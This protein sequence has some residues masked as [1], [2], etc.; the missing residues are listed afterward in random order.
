M[1]HMGTR[2]PVEARS[3][4]RGGK[5]DGVAP[6]ANSRGKFDAL[7]NL[8][9]RLAWVVT[10]GP[11]LGFALALALHFADWYDIGAVE[12]GIMLGMH[13]S[14]LVGVELGFHRLFAHRSYRTHKSVEIVF[15]ALG[16]M[17]FQGPAIWWAATH[18]NHHGHSDQLGDPHSPNLHGGGAWGAIG[19]FFHAHLGW[20]FV[21][22]STRPPGWSRLGHDL[23]RQPHIFKIHMAYVYWL[24][25][26]FAIPAVV[27]GFITWSWQGGFLGFL[28]GG[29]VR[30]FVMNHLTYWCVNSVAH[31]IGARPFVTGDLSTNN[32]LFAI[33]TLGQTWHNNHH[34]FPNS[35]V[36]GVE[37]WQVDLGACILRVLEK[38]GLV[39]DLKV[40]SERM[41]ASKRRA[42][43]PSG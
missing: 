10:L 18:R 6:P 23:Y 14:C 35:A 12:V 5:S 20:L 37:W 13:I 41:I 8:D 4:M 28:W 38:T 17:A 3:D 25:A 7:A 40:P 11:P 42:K 43:Q 29:P 27:G 21:A 32:A 15:G 24:F 36:M 34:A 33:P 22:E 30:I 26:G 19:G 1:A 2:Q 16:S 39:W 31:S 9:R